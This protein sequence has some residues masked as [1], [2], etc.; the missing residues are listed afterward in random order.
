M[1]S[2]A[3]KNVRW[4][5]N[6]ES[7]WPRYKELTDDNKKL[8]KLM[9]PRMNLLISEMLMKNIDKEIEHVKYKSL[10]KI[11]ESGGI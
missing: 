9:L 10:G 1:H 6:R 3:K 5:L 2:G 7:D 11:R 4:N 8:T